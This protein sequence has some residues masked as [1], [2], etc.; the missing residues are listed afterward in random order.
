[1]KSSMDDHK[2]SFLVTEYQECRTAIGKFD[3]TLTSLRTDFRKAGETESSKV[4]AVVEAAC[5]LVTA[6]LDEAVSKLAEC[7]KLSR[8]GL[9]SH[10]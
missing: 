2:A 3:D 6:D 8:R 10:A 5:S 4:N 7:L 1:M 9:S